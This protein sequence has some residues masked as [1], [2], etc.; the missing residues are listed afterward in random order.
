M[1]GMAWRNTVFGVPLLRPLL[2]SSH[3]QCEEVCR[4][5]GVT[6][7][8]DAS[9]GNTHQLRNRIRAELMPIVSAIAPDLNQ[10]IHRFG[11]LASSAA[12]FVEQTALEVLAELDECDSLDCVRLAAL[13]DVVLGAVLRQWALRMKCDA[14][15][16]TFE[17][18]SDGAI[19]IRAGKQ[20]AL[21]WPQGIRLCI[22]ASR[23]AMHSC[24]TDS[25]HDFRRNTLASDEAR[26]NLVTKGDSN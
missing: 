24:R 13:P 17:L 5:A 6:W 15:S 22:S 10:R 18:I 4:A 21:H 12:D 19:A 26:R 25:G 14:D 7:F 16:L 3:A 23:V 20:C 2:A 9:N 11:E 8:E 1:T